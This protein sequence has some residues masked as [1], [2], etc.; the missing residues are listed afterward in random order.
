[1]LAPWSM[2]PELSDA[3]LAS[4]IAAADTRAPSAESALFRR[5]APRVQLYGLRHL[6]SPAAAQDLT[7]QVMVRVLEA[8]RAGRVE[9]SARL[10]SFIFG[11]CRNV[12]WDMRRSDERQR[13]I[14]RETA[15]LS[16]DVTPPE[17]SERDVLRLYTCLRAL[18]QR[19]AT[20]LRMSFME[21]RGSDEIA[22]RLELGAGNVRVIRHRA[23]A[24]LAACMERKDAS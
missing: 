20:V 23:L 4:L 6:K 16:V 24:K 10:S 17:H 8:I 21:D 2:E 15:A 1:M 7:Q 19:E 9:D 12:T 5:Y 11:T 14:E 18:P 22:S 13:K 3:E